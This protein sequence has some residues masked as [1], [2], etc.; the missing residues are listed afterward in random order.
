MI[1]RILYPASQAEACCESYIE[2]E[3]Y[4]VHQPSTRVKASWSVCGFFVFFYFVSSHWARLCCSVTLSLIKVGVKYSYF[5]YL[6][7][8]SRQ[9]CWKKLNM[10]MKNKTKYTVM[11]SGNYQTSRVYIYF[12]YYFII[13]D[14]Y[15]DIF[16]TP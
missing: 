14:I 12:C 16:Y 8:T 5:I 15:F 13:F 3:S 6:M 7:N 2:P 9:L 11:R 10:F 1:V 4:T